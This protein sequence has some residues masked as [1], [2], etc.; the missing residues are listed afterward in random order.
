MYKN[1]YN[2]RGV[3]TAWHGQKLRVL[4][5]TKES[6]L[7]RGFA[8]SPADS[9]DPAT[10]SPHSVTDRLPVSA[11]PLSISGCGH[12][13]SRSGFEN[14]LHPL[15][16]RIS[17]LTSSLF[18]SFWALSI[19]NSRRN[20]SPPLKISTVMGVKGLWSVSPILFRVLRFI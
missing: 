6:S 17:S 7:I 18:P 20:H 1:D 8:G 5:F 12:N 15:F 10:R 4:S 19:Y 9:R 3:S 13:V 2:K 16:P 11:I 14:G